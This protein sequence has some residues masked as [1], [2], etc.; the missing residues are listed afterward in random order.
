MWERKEGG[1][2]T[3]RKRTGRKT[4]LRGYRNDSMGKEQGKVFASYVLTRTGGCLKK[5]KA[6]IPA[7]EKV[8]LT[9]MSAHV[10]LGPEAALKDPVLPVSK[11]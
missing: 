2:Q 6:G 8:A 5:D 11:W 4:S 1:G 7:H 10:Q 3:M 9:K